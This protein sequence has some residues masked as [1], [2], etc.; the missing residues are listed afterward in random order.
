MPSTR[1]TTRPIASPPLAGDQRSQRLRR[2]LE[3]DGTAALRGSKTD[4]K[5]A[6]SR[7][8]GGASYAVGPDGFSWATTG[9]RKRPATGELASPPPAS[10]RRR[11]QSQPAGPPESTISAPEGKKRKLDDDRDGPDGN[12]LLETIRQ[13]KRVKVPPNSTRAARIRTSIATRLVSAR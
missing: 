11:G 1:S 9:S 2:Q 12:F 13:V 6:A 10:K 5:P 4:Q 7:K 3:I 8:H